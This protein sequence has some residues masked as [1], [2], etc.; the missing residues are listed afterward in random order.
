MDR[1]S[2]QTGT[3]GFEILTP[4][5]ACFQTE[6]VPLSSRLHCGL[7]TLLTASLVS[8]QALGTIGCKSQEGQP[9]Q[10]QLELCRV[11]EIIY[12]GHGPQ[13][14]GIII[15]YKDGAY[16]WKQVDSSPHIFTGRH[17]IIDSRSGKLNNELLQQLKLSEHS[18]SQWVSVDGVPTCY[19]E[20]DDSKTRY[21]DCILELRKTVEK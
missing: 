18:N 7:S 17:V 13:T 16:L 10:P 12:D 21:R 15:V 9:V 2:P 14:W 19:F 8:L 3:P 20:V 6:N 1:L 4:W 5:S 11:R